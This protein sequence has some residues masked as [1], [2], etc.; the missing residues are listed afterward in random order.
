M[1]SAE[2]PEKLLTKVER[3]LHLVRD[4]GGELT[5]RGEFLRLHQAVLRGAQVSS[6]FAS[7]RV[8]AC[9]SSNKRTFSIAITAWSAK[10]V[11]SSTCL[12]VN[13]CD[14]CPRQKDDTDRKPF[15]QQRDAKRRA[16]AAKSYA[17][18]QLVVRVG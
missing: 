14:L 11:T 9:T 15:T 12:S 3:V 4:A 18:G 10:V 8:R 7:S 17:L 6:D 16:I 1:S 13:G 2:R 5:K